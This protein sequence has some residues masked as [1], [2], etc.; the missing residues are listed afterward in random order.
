MRNATEHRIALLYLHSSCNLA[1]GIH[2]QLNAVLLKT[3]WSSGRLNPLE[4]LQSST[5]SIIKAA[6]NIDSRSF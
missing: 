3:F 2:V 1:C 6:N 4:N 5:N